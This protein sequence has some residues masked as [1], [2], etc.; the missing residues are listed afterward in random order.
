LICIKA[1][2]RQ[3]GYRKRVMSHT[4]VN[5]DVREEIRHGR[6]PFGKIMQ[7]VARLK[8]SEQLLLIAPFEPAPLYAVLAGQGFS[9]QSKPTATGDWEVLFTRGPGASVEPGV[10]AAPSRQ[11]QG[12]QHQACSGPPVLEVDA[13]GLEPPQPLMKILEALVTL[14]EG[15][16]L[17]ALTD[18]R[19]MH[20]YDQLAERGF[21]G[22]SEE[23][24]DGGFVTHVRRR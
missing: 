24:K 2:R 3:R 12:S 19:P 23:Q 18:R 21:V 4:T 8:D 7:T 6:E 5:L 9:H 11:P 17:R 16:R 20:L 22:E 15:A 14:P 1:G 13:R 10:T